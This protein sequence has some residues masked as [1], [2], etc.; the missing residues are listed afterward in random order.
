MEAAHLSI[1]QLR[2]V[3]PAQ[4]MARF[5]TLSVQPILFDEWTLV[6]EWGRIGH[7]GTVRQVPYLSRDEAAAVCTKLWK[8]KLKRGYA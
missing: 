1:V 5:S 8:A 3:D 7:P 2:R 4:S 6:R